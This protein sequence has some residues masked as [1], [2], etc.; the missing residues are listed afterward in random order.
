MPRHT[1]LMTLAVGAVLTFAGP[2]V[3]QDLSAKVSCLRGNIAGGEFSELDQRLRETGW[4]LKG[5]V[6]LESVVGGV[7]LSVLDSAGQSVC[8]ETANN[9]TWCRFRVDLTNVDV[10][11]IKVNNSANTQSTAYEVCA[12]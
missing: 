6:Q 12:F 2:S 5:G 4:D 9:S 11:N 3:A 10:F 1:K 7:T 8:E